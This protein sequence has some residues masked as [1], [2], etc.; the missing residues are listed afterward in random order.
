MW[1]MNRRRVTIYKTRKNPMKP[2]KKLVL[3]KVVERMQSEQY[4]E[5]E[6][7][8]NEV[9]F[10][11]KWSS[12]SIKQWSVSKWTLIYSA[13]TY[14]IED[15]THFGQGITNSNNKGQQ[16]NLEPLCFFEGGSVK[17]SL[18]TTFLWSSLSGQS[19][20]SDIENAIK[21]NQLDKDITREERDLLPFM[22]SVSES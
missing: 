12:N 20:D 10:N 21:I 6:E 5:E 18:S 14:V 15:R 8:V 22:G 9:I 11:Y 1:Q 4:A 2:I 3:I 7:E 16:K 13:N 17:V 19:H